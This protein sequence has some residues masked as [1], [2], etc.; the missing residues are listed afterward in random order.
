M[1]FYRRDRWRTDGERLARGSPPLEMVLDY[2][3]V[4]QSIGRYCSSETSKGPVGGD[5][6]VTRGRY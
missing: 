1:S 2:G 6:R 4:V 3:G 5:R